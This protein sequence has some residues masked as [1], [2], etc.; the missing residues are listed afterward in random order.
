[1]DLVED[2]ELLGVVGEVQLRLGQASPVRRGLQ[3]QI[4]RWPPLGDRQGKR[5]LA[6]LPRPDQGDGGRCSSNP[7][8]SAV[9]RLSII[10]AIIDLYFRF[11]RIVAAAGAPH[12]GGYLRRRRTGGGQ[13]TVVDALVCEPS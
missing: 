1:M 10:R 8:T 9:T 4:D 3:V 12:I 7:A 11:A 5:G 13:G 2:H 6:G